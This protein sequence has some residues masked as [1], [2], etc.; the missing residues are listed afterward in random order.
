MPLP[1]RLLALACALVPTSF[2][3]WALWSLRCLFALYG[4]GEVFPPY[5]MRALSDVAVALLFTVLAGFVMQAP[6]SFALTWNLGP[7]HRE[8]SLGLGWGDASTSFLAGAAYVIARVMREI[9]DE[10]AKCV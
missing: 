2:T 8:I 1:F 10:N 6:I 9:A 5:A 7:H 3:M 4:K